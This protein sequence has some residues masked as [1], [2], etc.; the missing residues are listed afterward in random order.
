[1]DTSRRNL[2]D[3]IALLTWRRERSH[4]TRW[5]SRERSGPRRG[6]IRAR[7]LIDHEKHVLRRPTARNDQNSTEVIKPPGTSY[8]GAIPTRHDQLT[9]NVASGLPFLAVLQLVRLS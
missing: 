2:L 4:T 8:R 1:M 5:R 9:V 6:A 3:H 7:F